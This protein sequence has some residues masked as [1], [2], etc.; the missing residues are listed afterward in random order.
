MVYD[1]H[2]LFHDLTSEEAQTSTA[3]IQTPPPWLILALILTYVR[4]N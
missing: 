2:A 3:A 1:L 4:P